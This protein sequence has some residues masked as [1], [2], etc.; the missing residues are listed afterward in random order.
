[1]LR[2]SVRAEASP[3]WSGWWCVWK[4][5]KWMITWCSL[6]TFNIMFFFLTVKSHQI[7]LH[8]PPTQWEKLGQSLKFYS[9]SWTKRGSSSVWE[10]G[11]SSVGDSSYLV[12]LLRAGLK[13][14][15]RAKGCI[16]NATELRQIW[17]VSGK[18]HCQVMLNYH[19]KQTD[20]STY[21]LQ[22]FVYIGIDL[23]IYIKLDNRV[24]ILSPT[25]DKDAWV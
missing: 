4:M 16:Q 18:G 15:L 22:M 19:R 9:P 6:K 3:G 2:C 5:R 11:N 14:Q 17:C 24:R 8:S 1:M 13:A 10:R 21:D 25:E 12:V 7:C 20:Q 23:N